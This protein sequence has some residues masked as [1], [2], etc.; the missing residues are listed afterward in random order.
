M[1][2]DPFQILADELTLMRGEIDRLQRTSLNKD[3]ANALNDIVAKAAEFMAQTTKAAP[4]EIQAALKADRDQLAH[5]AGL[6]ATEA[7]QS[8]MTE[9]RHGS[10]Q[11]MW[12][13]LRGHP[14][15]P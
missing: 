12:K 3:E 1:S 6:V 9:I 15:G 8:V 5:S 10:D 11:R 13:A 4:A 7:A 14:K 2:K